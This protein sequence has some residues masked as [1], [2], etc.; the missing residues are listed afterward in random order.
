M[1]FESKKGPKRKMK[2]KR[3]FVS[4]KVYLFSFYYFITPFPLHFKNDF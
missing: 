4:L 2:E 1:R 3:C